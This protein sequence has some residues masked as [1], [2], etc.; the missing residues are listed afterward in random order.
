[1]NHAIYVVLRRDHAVQY[2][3]IYHN[4][5]NSMINVMIYNL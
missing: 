3:I 1:M 2:S 4:T 5:T